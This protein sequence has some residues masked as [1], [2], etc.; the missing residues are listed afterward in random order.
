MIEIH[1]VCE[2]LEQFAPLQ[3]A[4]EWDN[5]GLLIGDRRRPV[6][7]IMTCLTVTPATAAEAESDRV[8][9]IVTHHP[10]P[11]RPL[12]RITS[13]DT[14]GRLLLQLIRANVAVFSP[15][16]A[17]DSA[18]QGINQRL[19]E[20][21]G[22]RD[23]RPL[24]PDGATASEAGRGRFGRL[25][26]RLS[27]TD[28]ARRAKDW[29]KIDKLGWVGSSMREV[30]LVAVGCGSAGQFLEPAQRCGC[31]ALITGETNFHTCL[32]A[33]AS[34][35]ALLLLGHFASERFAVEQLADVL[36]QRFDEIDIWASR[37]ERDPLQWM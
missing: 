4:E 20:G 6:Q 13:D 30:S 8:E 5:V 10:F 29:L 2:F 7:R 21:L 17:F 25:A 3:L 14:T 12:K 22:L 26:E 9:L 28:L 37:R 32:E 11:F 27:L 24:I 36:R 23:V 1:T 16:T 35:T 33:E 15:H 19:A 34:E 31:E 18:V